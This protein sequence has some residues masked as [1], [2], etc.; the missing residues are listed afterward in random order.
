MLGNFF[1]QQIAPKGIGD[2]DFQRSVKTNSSSPNK[3]P[4]G[5]EVPTMNE[6]SIYS[7]SSSTASALM[8]IGITP[9]IHRV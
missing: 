4:Q 1:R 8:G 6:A 7:A 5:F 3:C 2:L 9:S